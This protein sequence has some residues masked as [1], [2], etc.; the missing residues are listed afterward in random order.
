MSGKKPYDFKH[1]DD[2]INFTRAG[3]KKKNV[4]GK[5]LAEDH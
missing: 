1:S 2:M 4:N 5:E 3:K